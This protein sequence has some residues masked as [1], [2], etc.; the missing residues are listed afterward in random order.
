LNKE[1]GFK[2]KIRKFELITNRKKPRLNTM[3]TEESNRVWHIAKAGIAVVVLFC[4]SQSAFAAATAATHIVRN[5]VTVDYQDLGANP[6]SSTDF[7][8]ITI[9]LIEAAPDAVL[10]GT[11]TDALNPVSPGELLSIVY[12]VTSNSNGEDE[13][14]LD[15]GAGLTLGAGVV[16]TDNSVVTFD[17][18]ATSA[19]IS[20]AGVGVFE[21]GDVAADAGTDISVPADSVNADGDLNGLVVGNIIVL[22]MFVGGDNVCTINKIED[23]AGGFEA[24]DVVIIEVDNCSL[25]DG[26]LAIGDQIGERMEITLTVTIDPASLAGTVTVDMDV[27][28]TGGAA[29]TEVDG[30]VITVVLAD[31]QIYKYVRNITPATTGN[32]AGNA[33]SAPFDCLTINGGDIYFSSGVTALPTEQLEYMVLL[34]N[35]AGDVQNVIVTDPFVI[36]T[37]Y[38]AMSVQVVPDGTALDGGFTCSDVAGAGTC[39]VTGTFS[40]SNSDDSLGNPTDFGGVDDNVLPSDPSDDIITVYAGH[41]GASANASET[42]TGGVIDTGA[43]S[44]VR[45]T[46]TID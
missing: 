5:T 26:N 17:L 2:H 43:V 19:A 9:D 10:N 38:D 29:P 25:A 8:D 41:N 46:V 35:N 28:F 21:T 40:A 27:D 16:A 33:C 18:G 11:L 45:Y 39:D 1:L 22:D 13:Y 6:F 14:S 23:G 15:S 7:V 37:T 3:K 34:Y 36:F 4:A 30:T 12:T 32:S 44:V 31:L 42:G 20:V 24:N